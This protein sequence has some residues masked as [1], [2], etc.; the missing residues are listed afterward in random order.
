MAARFVRGQGDRPGL[1]WSEHIASAHWASHF[2]TSTTVPSGVQRHTWHDSL[3]QSRQGAAGTDFQ[4]A[5]FRMGCGEL[6]HRLDPPHRCGHLGSERF[7]RPSRPCTGV[8]GRVGRDRKLGSP[9]AEA[10]NASRRPGTAGS[11]SGE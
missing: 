1:E 6:L 8:P 7:E 9:N 11:I 2:S 3:E 10:R 4:P 5:C